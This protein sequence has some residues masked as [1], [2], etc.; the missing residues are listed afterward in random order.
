MKSLFPARVKVRHHYYRIKVVDALIEYRGR[1]LRGLCCP[2]PRVIWISTKQTRRWQISTFK[3]ELLHAIKFEYKIPLTH[4]TIFDLELP[5]AELF[6]Q[7]AG[8]RR[9]AKMWKLPGR[10]LP[11]GARLRRRATASGRRRIQHSKRRPRN[12]PDR[13]R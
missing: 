7:N 6:I 9:Y 11:A 1:R 12:G 2:N 5:L 10:P 8:M 3:H 13:H 4:R